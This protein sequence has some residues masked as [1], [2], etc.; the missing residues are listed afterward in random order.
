MSSR[1]LSG[2]GATPVSPWTLPHIEGSA[3]EADRAGQGA[4]ATGDTV[5]PPPLP[6]AEELEAIQRQAREEGFSHGREE[7]RREGL[8]KMSAQAQRFADLI[9]ALGTPF[10]ELDQEVEEQLIALAVAMTRQLVRREVQTDPG[11]IVQAVREALSV[12]PAASR[13]IR[14]HLHPEDAQLVRETLS[15]AEQERPWQIVDDP[16]LSR[17]DCRVCTDSS[18]IDARL[19]TRLNATINAVFGGGRVGDIPE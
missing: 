3:S 12:L 7:G 4:S 9:S 14:V 10:A 13:E 17:G 11:Y 15:L 8:E 5:P 2:G 1:I 19:E 6:T 16:V 18:Q